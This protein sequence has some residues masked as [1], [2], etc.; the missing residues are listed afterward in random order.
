MAEAFFIGIMLLCIDM[1]VQAAITVALIVMA[2]NEVIARWLTRGPVRQALF[3][4]AAAVLLAASFLTQIAL[5]AAV[6]VFLGEF[7]D[8]GVA[9][10]HSA[11]NYA[12]LGYGDMVMSP[13]ARLLGPLEAINGVLMGGF[14]ASTLFA[15]ASRMIG[16][17]GRG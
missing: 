9:Y 15:I 11:V 3:L 8:F 2:R 5:W 12:T 13:Q 1:G 17:A 16:R 14:S 4:Q 6:F 10:Y 7:S